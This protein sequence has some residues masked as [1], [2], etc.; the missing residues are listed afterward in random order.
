MNPQPFSS[1]NHFTLP[2]AIGSSTSSACPDELATRSSPPH[3]TNNQLRRPSAGT[4]VAARKR[5]QEARLP[6]DRWRISTV[7]RRLPGSPR[8]DAY[9]LR[10]V[11][12][13]ALERQILDV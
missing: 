3:E 6:P 1:L 11:N 10:C 12:P 5:G 2:T 13:F 8:C 9:A 7:Q 4:L